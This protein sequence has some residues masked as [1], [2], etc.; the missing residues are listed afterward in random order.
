MADELKIKVNGRE[1][2]VSAS[3]DTPLLY[4]L[5]T[6]CGCTA[7]ASA[8]AWRNAFLLVLADGVEIRSC[9]PRSPMSP[10]S[11]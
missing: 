11:R 4:V 10:A 8:A 2:P 5:A 9:S 1:W 6:S 3:P 7:R